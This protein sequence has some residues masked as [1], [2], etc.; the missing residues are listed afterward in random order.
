M[1]IRFAPARHRNALTRTMAW[2]AKGLPRQHAA[3]D[4]G[5]FDDNQALL[6]ETLRH[7]AAHGISAAERARSMAVTAARTGDA[8]AYTRWLAV[9]QM[10]DKRMA[11][12]LAANG[13][14]ANL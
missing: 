6:T 1:T 7:F 11:K 8:A 2:G 13:E 3:N 9:C 14:C 4:D 10:L 5:V 12:A